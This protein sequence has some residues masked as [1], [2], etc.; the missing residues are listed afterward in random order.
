MGSIGRRGCGEAVVILDDPTPVVMNSIRNGW[1]LYLSRWNDG[2]WLSV[3]GRRGVN[4]DGSDFEP[5]CR[6]LTRHL[7]EER[8]Y[9]DVMTMGP[10]F[11][12]LRRKQ[13]DQ[14]LAKNAPHRKSWWDSH[15]LIQMCLDEPAV[16]LCEFTDLIKKKPF[17]GRLGPIQEPKYKVD[18]HGTP[19]AVSWWR[20]CERR[21]PFG[22]RRSSSIVRSP[23]PR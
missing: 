9:G 23:R 13:V 12:K 22:V 20:R 17:A 4:R 21:R 11:Y 15:F 10:P 7:M 2:E 6:S 16:P 19:I 8:R 14:W 3:F 5:A 18:P 1:S